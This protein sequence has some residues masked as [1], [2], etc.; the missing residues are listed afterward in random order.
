M[1]RNGKVLKRVH[2]GAVS[3]I[4]T[5]TD[6]LG[7]GNDIELQKRMGI[8]HSEVDKITGMLT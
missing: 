1:A 4:Q 7:S 5:I 8:T 2:Y 6:Y 3:A